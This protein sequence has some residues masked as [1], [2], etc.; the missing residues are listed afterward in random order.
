MQTLNFESVHLKIKAQQ[1]SFQVWCLVRKKY[2]ILTPE[3][4]VRQ[5]LIHYLI[6]YK[7]YPMSW[8]TC[9]MPIKLENLS[10]KR[11]D[12]LILNA[13]LSV[14]TLIECKATSVKLNQNH[15]N[16]LMQ[17][18]RKVNAKRIILT[19]GLQHEIFEIDYNNQKVDKL[20]E[21]PEWG[22]NQ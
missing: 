20:L 3:E 21:F 16:Q 2:I 12:V 10:K 13:D 15:V 17:Y 7:H 8:M 19:N 18:N 9:E 6:D 5:H 4:W 22:K 14:H 11:C 1:Q